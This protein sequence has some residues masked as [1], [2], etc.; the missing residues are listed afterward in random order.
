[1]ISQQNPFDGNY[2][3]SFQDLFLRV[4][5]QN[6]SWYDTCDNDTDFTACFSMARLYRYYDLNHMLYRFTTNRSSEAEQIVQT[7]VYGLQK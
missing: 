3:Y 7:S 1:M 5:L 2:P 6:F 4:Q